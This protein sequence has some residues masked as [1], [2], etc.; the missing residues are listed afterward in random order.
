VE[1]SKIPDPENIW[2]AIQTINGDVYIYHKGFKEEANIK[3]VIK[4]IAMADHRTDQIVYQF[5]RFDFNPARPAP[6]STI[7]INRSIIAFAWYIDP[8]A[9]IIAK[10]KTAMTEMDAKRAGLILPGSREL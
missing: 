2:E 9:D 8:S 4:F 7:R 3:D 1:N 5:S 6:D 10:L